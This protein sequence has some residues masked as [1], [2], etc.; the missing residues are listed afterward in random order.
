MSGKIRTIVLVFIA[1]IFAATVASSADRQRQDDVARRGAEVMPF[2][3]K[4]T[5]HVF[6][7]TPDGGV[8]RVVAKNPA[9]KHQIELIRSHLRVIEKQFE[10]G[11]FSAPASI[12]GNEMPGLSELRTAKPGQID[13]AY[14]DIKAGGEI[15]YA[16][17]V[18][19]LI[20]TLHRWIDAQLADHGPDAMAGHDHSSMQR[21]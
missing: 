19:A 4:A 8:Q 7:K 9:D 10:K 12:H 2:D 18:P 11:N 20:D 1:S 3:L 14:R 6:T 15:K 13:V 17:R 5:T 16:T 21:H